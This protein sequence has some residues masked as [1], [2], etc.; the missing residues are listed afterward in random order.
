[1]RMNSVN[2]AASQAADG[3]R[4]MGGAGAKKQMDAV[5][6]SLRK[7]IENAQKRLQELS[8]NKD[9]PIEEKMK[10]R[11]EI[12]QEITNL[13]QALR[14]HEM[15]LRKE[16]QKQ[17]QPKEQ[18]SADKKNA[19]GA[20]QGGKGMSQAGMEAIVSAD[21][22]IKQAQVQGSVA[23][24]LEGRARVLKTEIKQDKGNT[25]KKEA[26]LRD[27]EQKALGAAASQM[28]SLAKAGKA[29]EG[30]VKTAEDGKEEAA[31]KTGNDASADGVSRA[32]KAAGI[33]G[34]KAAKGTRQEEE[35]RK[36]SRA[37]AAQ[38]EAKEAA[39]VRRAVYAHVDVRL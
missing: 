31:S 12:Q 3:K 19:G 28:E 24:K 33:A 6:K 37:E 22:Q 11:Q 17:S 38:E 16:Q 5:S 21:S 27:V 9:M 25:E 26:E 13:T 1:M 7:Q 10:R 34:H 8:S 2:V 32:G 30:P 18:A 14:Q 39:A 4:K 15:E 36:E 23:T 29:M 35:S 20:K